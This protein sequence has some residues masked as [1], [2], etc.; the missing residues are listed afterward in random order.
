MTASLC[1]WYDGAGWVVWP[2][3]ACWNLQTKVE[4]PCNA[5][6]FRRGMVP[7]GETPAELAGEAP[8][9]RAESALLQQM[10][11]AAGQR[12]PD[13]GRA[14]SS[15]RPD[16]GTPIWRPH[17]SRDLTPRTPDTGQPAKLSDV[18]AEFG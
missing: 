11:L 10:K 12:D 7:A 3:Q 17:Q 8:A 13:T 4:V 15:N 14:I 5:A 2:G 9:P 18:L 6:G 1:Q 16:G